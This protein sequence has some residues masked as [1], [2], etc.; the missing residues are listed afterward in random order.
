MLLSVCLHLGC[1][2]PRSPQRVTQ[3]VPSN[4]QNITCV[5]QSA[6]P[7]GGSAPFGADPVDPK[8][9]Q[10]IPKGMPQNPKM[11]ATSFTRDPKRF[12]K[13][14]QDPPKDPKS[15]IW[16][17]K[18]SRSHKAPKAQHFEILD[19]CGVDFGLLGSMGDSMGTFRLKDRF[20]TDFGKFLVT[21]GKPFGS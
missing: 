9:S 4:H 13:I 1:P 14:P 2:P 3:N 16:V 10:E 5:A 11:L 7:H 6:L 21:L 12:P 20:W 18:G 17:P 19:I 15:K 8:D